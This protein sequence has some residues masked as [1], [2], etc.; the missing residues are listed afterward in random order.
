LSGF[1]NISTD[2]INVNGKLNAGGYFDSYWTFEYP[3]DTTTIKEERWYDNGFLLALIKVNK[4]SSDTLEYII[5]DRIMDNL[6]KLKSL[7]NQQNFKMSDDWFGVEFN[8]GYHDD[9]PKRTNQMR[10]NQILMDQLNFI[11]KTLQ[12]FRNNDQIHLKLTRKFEFTLT[13]AQDSLLLQLMNQMVN[14]NNKINNLITKPS[15]LLRKDNSNTLSSAYNKLIK[16]TNKIS[17]INEITDSIQAGAFKYKYMSDHYNDSMTN[18]NVLDTFTFVIGKDIIEDTLVVKKQIDYKNSII[19]DLYEYAVELD[20][21]SAILETKIKDQ[22]DKYESQERIDSLDHQI[23]LLENEVVAQFELNDEN[24]N[25]GE[26]FQQKLYN[27]IKEKFINELKAKYLNNHLDE[28][29]LM[30]IGNQLICYYDFLRV[31]VE[32]IKIA[33]ELKSY[34]NDSLFTTLVD[35]PFDTRKLETKILPGVQNSA[36]IL[37]NHYA[38]QMLNAKNCEQLS[39]EMNKILELKERVEVLAKSHKNAIVLQYDKVLRRER[40]PLRIERILK[41]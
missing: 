41:L 26:K 23:A 11:S 32:A 2:S 35:N 10:G 14:L 9:D 27:S 24:L 3:Q 31:N 29:N 40:V 6:E 21:I 4:K 8:L 38:N 34:W 22:L 28:Q 37:L 12:P 25:L 30:S 18:L 36:T 39:V 15:F 33:G 20:Q 19:E 5:Y 16:I 17:K 7:P 13:A 1:V